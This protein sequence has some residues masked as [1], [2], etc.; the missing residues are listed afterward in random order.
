MQLPV[1]SCGQ[2]SLWNPQS[3]RSG[4][5]VISS[6]R[7]SISLEQCKQYQKQKQIYS[8][9]PQ[10]NHYKTYKNTIRITTYWYMCVKSF[11]APTP[12][13]KSKMRPTATCVVWSVLFVHLSVCL[14]L[15]SVLWRCWF[16]D[17][18]GIRPVKTECWGA[19]V[20]VILE[21]GADMHMAQLMPLP[22]TVSCFSKIQIGFTFLVSAH[23]G[24][25]GKKA[26]KQVSVCVC[27]CLLVTTVSFAKTA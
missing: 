2:S 16:G 11:L 22:L 26:I 8:T 1:L 19:C 3:G 12:R 14:L 4:G 6:V 24:S 7:S 10:Q 27:V 20:V 9:T 21:Q 17:R 18:K 23:A 13:E 5:S 25:P 15:P